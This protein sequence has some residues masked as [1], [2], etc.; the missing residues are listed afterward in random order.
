MQP[1]M[2]VLEPRE[3]AKKRTAVVVGALL[4][5]AIL[6]ARTGLQ[7]VADRLSILLRGVRLTESSRIFHAIDVVTLTT[8]VL[9]GI[10]V[11]LVIGSLL[12]DCDPAITQRLRRMA[13]WAP[14]RA[15]DALLAYGLVSAIILGI[16]GWAFLPSLGD[17]A[18][19]YHAEIGR[20]LESVASVRDLLRSRSGLIGLVVIYGTLGPIVGHGMTALL[21]TVIGLTVLLT[22]LWQILRATGSSPQVAAL[23]PP[24][25]LALSY[26]AKKSKFDMGVCSSAC[27]L[28]PSPR[29]LGIAFLVLAIALLL[30]GRLLGATL[31]TVFAASLHAL[32]GFIPMLL[33]L[34]AGLVTLGLARL[35][36]TDE[37]KQR[38]RVALVAFALLLL[39]F[40]RNYNWIPLLE[41]GAPDPATALV[42]IPSSL[43]LLVLGAF[44][45]ARADVGSIPF[46]RPRA[47][48]LMMIGL[49]PIGVLL[50]LLRSPRS[51]A[52]GGSFLESVV[53]YETLIQD[54]RRPQ[55][56]LLSVQQAGTAAMLVVLAAFALAALTSQSP[57]LPRSERFNA[58][59]LAAGGF[60]ALALTTI[61]G[62]L[63]EYSDLP[64]VTSVLPFRHLW[65]LALAALAGIGRVLSQHV[66]LGRTSPGM[67]GGLAAWAALHGSGY[68]IGNS[69]IGG[70]LL[71]L[72][73]IN[74]EMLRSLTATTVGRW[75]TSRLVTAGNSVRNGGPLVL[76]VAAAALLVAP[77]SGASLPIVGFDAS[78]ERISRD[79][80]DIDRDIISSARAAASLV[81]DGQVVLVPF[82][83]SGWT[84]F[85]LISGRDLAFDY[86]SFGGT[87]AWYEGFRW[88]CDPSYEFDPQQ[89]FSEVD[90]PEIVGCMDGQSPEEIRAV[91]AR[92]GARYGVVPA[93]Q[94]DGSG[95]LH[96]TDSGRFVLVAFD[97][98]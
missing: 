79:G 76:T 89:D 37:T 23:L 1:I 70:G 50:G 97:R 44:A 29:F 98:Q 77:L 51:D 41:G 58:Q 17:D 7:F 46:Q 52:E 19:A 40:V 63:N 54:L 21:L 3:K 86:N 71:V 95:V 8:L 75:R 11:V 32:D 74:T 81:G 94:W 91:A 49:V 14:V 60:A 83:P 59:W 57:D 38:A 31:I 22:G 48:W 90:V 65:L 10:A 26:G 30:A 93:S 36:V 16:V 45:L 28:V 25:S 43:A 39:P 87:Q 72:L 9:I 61:G 13:S 92:F 56:V 62:V 20:D 27:T 84:S 88:M 35:D 64:L 42:L 12:D 4:M 53:L 80:G 34:A 47:L 5:V 67:L 18:T 73:L 78:L 68:N 69:I 6:P 15:R 85:K 66:R 33:L 96:V 55:A 2:N 82:R 24:I